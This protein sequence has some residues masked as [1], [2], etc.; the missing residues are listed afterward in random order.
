MTATMHP[1]RRDCKSASIDACAKIN[2][3]L[4]VLGRRADG[5]QDIQSLVLGIDLRDRVRISPTDETSASITCDVDSLCGPD[6]LA[7]QAAALM[8]SRFDIAPGLHVEVTKR[9][10]IGA[11]LGGGSADAAATIRLCNEA[12]ELG[13]GPDELAALGADIGSDVP[14]FFHLPCAVVRGRGE[15][16][17][18]SDLRW[19]GW[20]LL[21]DVQEVVP[22]IDVYRHWQSSDKDRLPDADL[23][24]AL[25]AETADELNA[26]STNHLEPAVFRVASRVG[27][28]HADL[29]RRGHGPLRVSGAGS[30]LYKLFDNHQVANEAADRVAQEGFGITTMVVAAPVAATTLKN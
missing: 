20:A 27:R 12:Y 22:T 28:V 5:Y 24:A 7:F 17:E 11:G 25:T 8:A 30:V 6:N 3:T 13:L 15:I 4:E 1:T 21:V 14:L 9:I 16:V 26:L 19:S 23:A 29:Q 2:L 18:A 10:P